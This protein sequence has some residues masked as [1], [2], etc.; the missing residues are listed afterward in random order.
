VAG[1]GARRPGAGG[2]GRGGVFTV[3]VGEVVPLG[4]EV[5]DGGTAYLEVEINVETL[6]PRLPL[7]AVP[8]AFVAGTMA[9]PATVQGPFSVAFDGE[10]VFSVGGPDGDVS[11]ARSGDGLV[12]AGVV[13]NADGTMARWFNNVT[14]T[15][16]TV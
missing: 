14:G 11:Q 2:A 6:N 8:Y 9:A 4:H 7:S 1:A 12:K 16:P 3:L 5:F 15:A 10:P 13:V